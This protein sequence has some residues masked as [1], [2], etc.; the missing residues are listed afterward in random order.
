MKMLRAIVA[1]L[2]VACSVSVAAAN[3]C[4]TLIAKARAALEQYKKAP[5]LAAIKDA[6]IAAVETNLQAAESA[7]DAGQ[8]EEAMR[9]ANEALKA[10][11]K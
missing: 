8:H 9:Q 7:H 1:V 3:Q 6:K 10:L 5:G 4:P 2:I 11:G